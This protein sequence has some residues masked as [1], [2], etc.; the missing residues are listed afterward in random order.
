[1]STYWPAGLLVAVVVG[2]FPTYFERFP[3]F[4]GTSG[5]VHF[6]AATMLLWLGLGIAQ[7]ILV[8]RGRF[9]LHRRLG[10]ATYGL[11]PLIAAGFWLILVDGQLRHKQP[12][13]ILAT[14][15]DAWLF[16]AM[17]GLGLYYRRRR[18][19]H[20]RFMM[21]SMLPF[22]NPTLG[23]IFV[24]GIGMAVELVALIAL[25]VHARRRQLTAWPYGVALAA[26]LLGVA[27]LGA[28]MG[29]APAVPEQL[30][31]LLVA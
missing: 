31:Q 19:Y 26:F 5:A 17:A 1:M 18:E 6:H 7:P 8:R 30:W 24:P 12:E 3:G 22:L 11:L 21:L 16:F 13:L 15:F 25:L 9:D 4:A 20:A 29:A 23:R 27:A 28:V 10:R 14:V 2:F